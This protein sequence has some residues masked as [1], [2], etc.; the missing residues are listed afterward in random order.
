MGL[1]IPATGSAGLINTISMFAK[2][3]ILAGIFGLI[4]TALWF[5]QGTLALWLWKSVYAHYK[6]MG[7]SWEDARR[8]AVGGAMMSGVMGGIGS[9]G[10]NSKGNVN[11]RGYHRSGREDGMFHV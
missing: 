8:E 7:H 11:S 2:Q 3:N 5:I 6:G 1:G 10:G 4:D 9:G